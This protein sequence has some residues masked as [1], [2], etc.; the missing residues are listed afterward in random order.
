[1]SKCNNR[2]IVMAAMTLAVAALADAGESP[3]LIATEGESG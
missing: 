3:R 1:M 2:A